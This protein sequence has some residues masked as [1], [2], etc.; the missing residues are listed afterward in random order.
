MCFASL[1]E[2]ESSLLLCPA[3]TR[4]CAWPRSSDKNRATTVHWVINH[5]ASLSLSVSVSFIVPESRSV[6]KTTTVHDTKH[7]VFE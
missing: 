5:M 4:Y 3:A 2:S 1:K 7:S 6:H